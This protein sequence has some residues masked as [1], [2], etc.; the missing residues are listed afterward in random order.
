VLVLG[1]GLAASPD[2]VSWTWW[3]AL[4]L[5]GL[6]IAS[7]AWSVPIPNR[8]G[9]RAYILSIATIPHMLAATLLPPFL[10]G[11]LAGAAMLVDELRG[12]RR[13]S[14]LVVNVASA[15][16][17]V[18]MTALV[19][20]HLGLAGDQFGQ[21]D[22][23]QVL[24]FLVVAL[25]YFG[26]NAVL[27]AG[28]WAVAS[29]RSFR[30]TLVTHVRFTAAAELA[31][32]VIG[33]LVAFVWVHNPAWLVVGLFP[34][35]ISQLTLRYVAA[36]SSKASQLAALDGL[37]RVLSGTL[38]TE[39]TFHAASA[40]LQA[41][42][43]V[44]G[45]FLYLPSAGVDLAD[46]LAVGPRA[47]LVRSEL[48]RQA[49]GSRAVVRLDEGAQELRVG[50]E[51]VEGKDWL[52][53]PLV[54]GDQQHGCIGV[55][56]RNA[57]TFGAEQRD[58]FH[59]VAERVALTLENG[60]RAEEL[61]ISEQRALRRSEERFRSLIRNAADV[62]AILDPDGTIGYHS[63]AVERVWGCAPDSLAGSSIFARVHPGDQPRARV[64]LAQV[65]AEADAL[66]TSE[67]RLRHQN[68]TWRDCEVIVTNLL[69]DQG[70]AGLVATFRDVTERKMFE[71]ELARTAFHDALTGLPNRA[72]FLDRL[73]QAL[74]RATRQGRRVAV[75]FLDIDNFKVINDSLG[76]AA[77]DQLLVDV[78]RRL[79]A[80]V[81][82][83][84]TVARFG[85]DEFTI[86]LEEITD[87]RAARE[88]AE[89]IAEQLGAAIQLEDRRVV[90]SAS[91]GIALSTERGDAPESLLRNADLA[92]YCAKSGGKA[93][94]E[95]F[96][97]SMEAE[98]VERLEIESDLRRALERQEFRVVFQPIVSLETGETVEV[99]AL[100]RWQHPDRGLV[101]P[102]AFIPVAEETGLIVPIGQW[103]LEAACRQA[104]LWH[105]EHPNDPPLVMSVNLSARQF[106]HPGLVAD[107]ARALGEAEL[108]PS[109]LKL[110]I[111]ES[112]VMRDAEAATETLRQL[113]S[114]GI[115]LA[116]DDFGTGYSSL[117]Y[118]KRLPV[119]TLKID[120]SFVH[121]LGQ[122][123]QDTAIV[124]SIVAL[125][126]T[127]HL[128]VTAEGIEIPAQQ[129][130]LRHLGCDRGQGYLFGRPAPAEALRVTLARETRRDY[131]KQAA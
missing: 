107:I 52:A 32:A 81:R 96:D 39:E 89:R 94:A 110:E 37:G 16:V 76:H 75:L 13:P 84:D 119:D 112:V 118:L 102:P 116:I 90:V 125:A 47:E 50:G 5:L 58:F 33:G 106:Q 95:L 126:K 122:D 86:L 120:R 17:N 99:E 61:R 103:V 87:E 29:G 53:L 23:W 7:E 46:G 93:R 28:A 117:S 97:Q 11:V 55:V 74:Q 77:G 20:H 15:T 59:L 100:V 44:H 30:S 68:G 108:D 8:M 18:G 56:S 98:A 40:H 127:L 49:L 124:R 60:R 3:G 91:I 41:G 51:A 72:L 62:I 4:L 109:T 71:Q 2:S 80:S 65:A 70:V 66:L 24:A 45:M 113:K 88:T 12:R 123:D 21:G 82:S 92:M 25:T 1:A 43:A 42:R 31:I 26:V 83:Q 128:S 34:A 85:G 111:T 54:A 38:T 73:E 57:H 9:D 6:T 130:Q 14:R 36:S 115:R 22:A 19:A 48:V 105:A 78:A 114:L 129:A 79:A 131:L 121:G 63:P 64:L 10:A 104:R 35:V 69:A 101:P 67:L 27:L